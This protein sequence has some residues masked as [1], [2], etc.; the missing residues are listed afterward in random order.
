[1]TV[2]T[3]GSHWYRVQPAAAENSDA[4][5]KRYRPACIVRPFNAPSFK[6]STHSD[7]KS[8]QVNILRGSTTVGIPI[9]NMDSTT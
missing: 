6:S 1:L 5:A 4:P 7:R 3:K 2:D 9:T 8:L